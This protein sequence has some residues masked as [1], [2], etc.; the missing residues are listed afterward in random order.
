M[1]GADVCST[2]SLVGRV[3]ED[4]LEI[5]VNTILVHPVRVENPEVAAAPANTLLRNGLQTALGFDLVNT[6]ADGLA[7][8]GT[9]K[10]LQY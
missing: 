2:Y 4:D 6:L 9:Y 7:V 10:R 8:G 3:N 1:Q 5:L